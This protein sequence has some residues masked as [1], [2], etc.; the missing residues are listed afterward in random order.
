[1]NKFEWAADHRYKMPPN[2]RAGVR[3]GPLLYNTYEIVGAVEVV[4]PR[5]RQEGESVRLICELQTLKRPN[6]GGFFDI[7]SQSELDDLLGSMD[8]LH[9]AIL[10]NMGEPEQR[11]D[12]GMVYEKFRDLFRAAQVGDTFKYRRV[13]RKIDPTPYL[14]DVV[15]KRLTGEG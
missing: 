6:F 8:V 3:P 5:S 7:P 13:Y 10:R 11:V 12:V 4:N 9:W 2:R 14:P 15:G 1:M